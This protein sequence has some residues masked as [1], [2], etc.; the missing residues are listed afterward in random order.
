MVHALPLFWRAALS[1]MI[2]LLNGAGGVPA[3]YVEHNIPRGDVN[4]WQHPLAARGAS[5]YRHR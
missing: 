1:D 4:D 3:V 2:R 5:A